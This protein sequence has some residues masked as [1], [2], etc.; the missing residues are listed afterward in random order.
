M[1]TKVQTYQ[2]KVKS[3]N[4]ENECLKESINKA[5]KCKAEIEEENIGLKKR[6]K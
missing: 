3:V 1:E 6:L 4:Q 5:Q 2:S